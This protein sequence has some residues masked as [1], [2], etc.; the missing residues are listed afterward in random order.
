MDFLISNN[1]PNNKKNDNEDELSKIREVGEIE[2][3]DN[4]I[5]CGFCLKSYSSKS[6]LNK[7]LKDY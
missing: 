3:I 6:N 2:E 4:N 5:V 7:H 1:N